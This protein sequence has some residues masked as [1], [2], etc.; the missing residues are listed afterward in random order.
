[1][2]NPHPDRSLGEKLSI[3][4]GTAI[5]LESLLV[6]GAKG[7]GHLYMN[8]STLFRNY[9]GSFEDP[10]KIKRKEFTLGFISELN[11]IHSI[12]IEGITGN[13]SPIFYIT[14][15]KS[16]L[17]SF[18]HCKIKYAHTRAQID[19][20]DLHDSVITEAVRLLKGV[21]VEEYDLLINGKHTVSYM[22][23]SYPMDL[24]SHHKFR[25]LT[26]LESHTGVL[27]ERKNWISKL[28]SS[29]KY[30]NVPFNLLSIQILGDKSKWLNSMGRE[31]T[32]ML[33]DIAVYGNWHPLTT[34]EKVKFD[35][36]RTPLINRVRKTELDY[37]A[38]I[39]LK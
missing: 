35:I 25:N 38:K 14:R 24:L 15:G 21:L 39:S 31:W 23:T 30:S 9:A 11:L 7:V 6:D 16:I 34:M 20:E 5:P 32:N 4:I 18:K 33:L 12:V 8:I 22:I 1:M 19:Y 17:T 36:A 28:N 26:L 2:D 27:K 13:I 10:F 37:M 29:D 3:S